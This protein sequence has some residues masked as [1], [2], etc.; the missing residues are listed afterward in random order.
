MRLFAIVLL[1]A[2]FSA[3]T[4]AALA[5]EG[6]ENHGSSEP[7]ATASDTAAEDLT[8]GPLVL[9][10]STTVLLTGT[11]LAGITA[12]L[13]VRR[14]Q[15]IVWGA[16]AG[17]SV[18]TVLVIVGLLTTLLALP[19]ARETAATIIDSEVFVVLMTPVSAVLLGVATSGLYALFESRSRLG[20]VGLVSIFGATVTLLV[21]AA[22][23]TYF[24]SWS[25][26]PSSYDAVLAIGTLAELLLAVGILLVS[27]SAYQH[28]IF[29]KWS[30]LPLL[31]AV[32]ATP[33]PA[34]LA[35]LFF[36]SENSIEV[37]SIVSRIMV[38]TGWAVIG[39]LMLDRGSTSGT[40]ALGSHRAS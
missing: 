28:E 3:S 31:I 13:K 8:S 1:V 35:S 36:V 14:S 2:A 4:T 21:L 32:L 26:S 22:Y 37:V 15:L 30:T 27:L 17:A 38:G 23:N 24:S 11:T 29:G 25:S 20:R 16:I 12:M 33:L 9:Q 39:V 7:H 19:F 5:H 10:L 34:L 18:G 40:V 6:E